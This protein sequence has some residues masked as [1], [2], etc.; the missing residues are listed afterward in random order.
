MLMLNLIA[1]LLLL[2]LLLLLERIL[3]FYIL[4]EI[5]FLRS[6]FFLPLFIHFI[7]ITVFFSYFN[8][9]HLY[10]VKLQDGGNSA[11]GPFYNH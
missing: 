3:N 7:I 1:L 11:R 2:L 8:A 10:S 5:I 9:P 4:S 6:V